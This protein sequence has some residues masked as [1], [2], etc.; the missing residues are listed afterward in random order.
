M[1]DNQNTLEPPLSYDEIIDTNGL[2]VPFVPNIIT[3]N[4]EKPL[5]NGRYEAG[6][7]NHLKSLLKPDDRLLDLGGGLGLVAATAAKLLPKGEVLSIEAHPGLLPMIQE[8]WRLNTVSNATLKHGLIS[9]TSGAPGKFYARTD[10]WASSAEPKSRPFTAE[11]DVQT[12]GL[13]TLIRTFRPTIISCD[14]E[15]AEQDLFD[16]LDLSQ[17]GAIVLETHPKVNGTKARD[18]LLQT[19]QSKG[20]AAHPQPRPSTVYVLERTPNWPPEN[21]R[22]LLA[23]CM[24]DEGPFILEWLAW[25]KAIGIT[26]IVVFSNDCTDGTDTLLDHLDARGDLTH[27]PNP[28]SLLGSGYYQ[29]TALNYVQTMPVFRAADFMLSI[30]VDEFVNIRT[31][32]GTLES[33]LEN[34]PA[35]DVLS[36]SELNHGTN[37][38]MHFQPGWVTDLFPAHQ[39]LKPGRWRAKAGVKSL[40]RLSKR[41][42]KVRNHRPDLAIPPADAVW[43]NGSGNPVSS[44]ADDPKENG[45]DS[46]RARDL[47]SLEHYPLRSIDS[48]LV[49]AWR[50]DVVIK[51]KQVSNAYFRRR[52][53]GAHHEMDLSN[54]KSLARAVH[55]EF[56]KDMTLMALH[57]AC[58]AAHQARI[59]DLNADPAY[60][61]RRAE[62]VKIAEEQRTPPPA[63]GTDGDAPN[64]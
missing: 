4:I 6:E 56:E 21:P 52:N 20:L 36:I 59:D 39:S 54:G 45:L 19:L 57:E 35:F 61:A 17:V 33:L 48:F 37:D 13:D 14:I 51:G 40:T 30:D 16:D 38:Q 11:H 44:L 64:S 60:R 32:E 49:K 29:P 58:N 12:L 9:K 26:D 10:F 31:P 3:P 41:I 22:T 62:I 8:V 53:R 47:V 15:G 18:A 43:L 5:G 63:K 50:G 1:A 24:K 34:L 46:R 28:A 27:L 7:L 55:A 23:T 25:H 2:R 42:E